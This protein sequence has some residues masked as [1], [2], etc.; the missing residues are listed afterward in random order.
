[1]ATPAPK[2]MTLAEFLEWDDGTDTLYELIDGRVVAMP[3]T[4]DAHGTMIA[5]LALAIGPQP[6]PPCRTVG[7]AGITRP[8]RADSYYI[9]DLR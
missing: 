9:A 8:E 6:Q 5:N 2:R 4:S 1:M 7:N 3:P